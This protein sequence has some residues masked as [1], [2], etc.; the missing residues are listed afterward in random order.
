MST[1]EHGAQS[2][3]KALGPTPLLSGAANQAKQLKSR[4]NSWE[5]FCEAHPQARVAI[6]VQSGYSHEIKFFC[7]S[8]VFWEEFK[9]FFTER[10]AAAGSRS[11]RSRLKGELG[12]AGIDF[13]KFLALAID[14]W[15]A[16]GVISQLQADVMIKLATGTAFDTD[17]CAALTAVGARRKVAGMARPSSTVAPTRTTP[18]TSHEADDEPGDFT[19]PL[20]QAAAGTAAA[21]EEAEQE[22]SD[23]SELPITR[24]LS[25]KRSRQ[26]LDDDSDDEPSTA[27]A[28]AAS[29]PAN[30]RARRTRNPTEKMAES[31]QQATQLSCSK[32]NCLTSSTSSS[33]VLLT[34]AV[35]TQLIWRGCTVIMGRPCVLHSHTGNLVFIAVISAV[36]A[37][38]LN[39]GPE[40]YLNLL[41]GQVCDFVYVSSGMCGLFALI[42]ALGAFISLRSSANSAAGFLPSIYGSLSLFTAFWWMVAAITFTKRGQQADDDGLEYGSART[43]VIALLWIEAVLAFLS[44][45]LVVYDR[46]LFRRF[47]LTVSKTKSLLDLEDQA[48]FKKAYV[49]TQALGAT[50]V[51]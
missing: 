34:G 18:A 20:R 9:D 36:T 32:R 50:P 16:E 27:A 22:A 51:V 37:T 4:F 15:K 29:Y 11:E 12:K 14:L 30:K 24:R 45:A 3:S 41:P 23:S 47:R 7:H 21:V 1:H 33:L 35:G 25:Q 46:V 38:K 49:H 8:I 10:C 17:G 48:E 26:R 39:T 6:A 13:S 42:V 5:R 31:L 19:S 40:C 28:V 2:G 43:T 44:F